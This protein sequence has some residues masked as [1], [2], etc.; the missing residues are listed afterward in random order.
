MKNETEN[1][2]E[3]SRIPRVRWN[4]LDLITVVAKPAA[5]AYLFCDINVEAAQALLATFAE[6]GH[7]ITVTAILLKAIATAQESYPESMSFKM[8]EGE[9]VQRRTPV[10]G[11]TVERI[12][13]DQPA[14]FFGVIEDPISK[15]L[16]DIAEELRAY[17]KD[18]IEAVPQLRKEKMLRKIPWLLRQVGL[19]I[20]LR[21]P[22]LRQK[23][24]AATFGLTSLGKFGIESVL[25]PCVS[26]CIFGAGAIESRPVAVDDR[27]ESRELMT[28]TLSVDTRVMNMYRAGNFIADVKKLV[29]SALEQSITGINTSSN[30]VRSLSEGADN[31]QAA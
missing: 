3:F 7:K 17:G 4:V 18:D 29:E 28:L 30:N 20:G 9:C 31:K 10:A 25:A 6:A 15:P 21:V 14:V 13:D 22:S 19:W 24:N 23:T 16:Q 1:S 11:F 12:V 26:T 27:V 8:P 5:P 2:Y